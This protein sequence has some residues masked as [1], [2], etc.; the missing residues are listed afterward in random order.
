MQTYPALQN[1]VKAEAPLISKN[2]FVV[3]TYA[4]YRPGG[5]SMHCE[6]LVKY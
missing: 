5:Q 3:V 2:E 1:P 4:Q 6:A